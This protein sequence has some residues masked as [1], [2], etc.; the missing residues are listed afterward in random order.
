MASFINKPKRNQLFKLLFGPQ[1]T[2][3][4]AFL[5]T[6]VGSPQWKTCI[7]PFGRERDKINND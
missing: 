7:T 5:L 3:V 2:A 4:S 6:A 1:V